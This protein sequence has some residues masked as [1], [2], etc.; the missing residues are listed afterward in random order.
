MNA[1]VER[2]NA[3]TGDWLERASGLLAEADPGPTPF[4]VDELLVEQA[5][6]AIQGQPKT[7]KTWVELELVLA[8]VSG[9]LAFGRF[10]VVEPGPVILVL[11]ESGRAAL[12][13]RLGALTRGYAMKPETLTDL[14]FAANRRVRLDDPDWQGRLLD[15]IAA[16]EPRAVFLDPLARLK[17]AGRRENAQEEMAVLLDFM[18]QMR[19][20]G[21]CAVI[22]VHHTGHEGTHLRGSSDLESYWESKIALKRE[23]D[24]ATLSSQHREAEEG[25]THRFRQAWDAETR[26]LRLRLLEDER[27]DE[28]IRKVAEELEKDPDASANDVFKAIGGNRPEVLKAVAHLRSEKVVPTALVPPGTTPAGRPEGGTRRG[29]GAVGPPDEVPPASGGTEQPGTTPVTD[30]VA[31][32]GQIDIFGRTHGLKHHV[33]VEEGYCED[34]FCADCST[35]ERCAEEHYCQALKDDAAGSGRTED[36]P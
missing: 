10:K 22:F 4:L 14:H 15:A 6:A 9:R 24:E 11:E 33:A 18:R 21:G 29:G 17:T 20:E 28:T 12:H 8:I 34:R 19:D 36:G 25:A 27:R 35:P 23:A 5:L 31:M 30:E 26:S 13:R 1:A 32:P 16:V 2:L 7:W 3:V